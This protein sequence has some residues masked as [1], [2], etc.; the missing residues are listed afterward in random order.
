MAPSR[1]RSLAVFSLLTGVVVANLFFS[2]RAEQL[3]FTDAEFRT[4]HQ[5]QTERAQWYIQW[6]YMWFPDKIGA[7][8]F[9]CVAEESP[10]YAIL[11]GPWNLRGTEIVTDCEPLNF[12][13]FTAD[14]LHPDLITEDV[15]RSGTYFAYDPTYTPEGDWAVMVRAKYDTFVMVHTDTLRHLGLADIQVDQ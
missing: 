2:P 5:L 7:I 10:H 12:S 9:L 15:R 1:L 3:F 4:A 13:E 6:G 11:R 14:R 8:H